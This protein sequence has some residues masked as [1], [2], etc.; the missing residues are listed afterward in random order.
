MARAIGAW[1]RSLVPGLDP[2]RALSRGSRTFAAARGPA[3]LLL[4]AAVAGGALA[5]VAIADAIRKPA[6][7]A[8]ERRILMAARSP[9]DVTDAIGPELVEQGIRDLTALGSAVVITTVTAASSLYFLFRGERQAA[10]V[11]FVSVAGAAAL[12]GALKLA[13]RRPDP[14]LVPNAVMVSSTS[15]PSGHSMMSMVTYSMLAGLTARSHPGSRMQPLLVGSA[16]ILSLLVGLSRIYLGIHWPTDV[17]AGWALGGSWTAASW[18]A[19]TALA[20]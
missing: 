2:G 4:Y 9:G 16:G 1:I 7:Q 18:A 19:A 10:A 17:L 5:F 6:T 12:V 20:R 11:M 3:P 14:G 8:V 15:F 13:F